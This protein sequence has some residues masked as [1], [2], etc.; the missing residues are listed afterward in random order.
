MNEIENSSAERREENE[1]VFL[2]EGTYFLALLLK[3]KIFIAAFVF[4]ATAGAV[5]ASLMMDNWYKAKVN[6]IPPQQSGSMLE[7]AT[8]NIK[9]TL[10]DFGLTKLTGDADS[11]SLL[12]IFN[13]RSIKD[14]IIAKYN[15]PEVYGIPDTSM[16]EIRAELTENFEAAY[17]EEGNY[18]VSVWDKDPRRASAMANDFIHYFNIISTKIF[19]HESIVNKNYLEKRIA[20]TDSIINLLVDSLS[21]YSK[22]YMIFSPE[23]QASAISDALSDLKAKS[24]EAQTKYNIFRNSYGENDPM[25]ILQKNIASETSRQLSD[26][27][28]RPGFAG[29]FSLNQATEVGIEFI[30]MYTELETYA[31]V[32][33]FLMPSLEKAKLDANS[34]ENNLLYLDKAIP[35]ERK[36]KPKRSLI[37]VGVGAGSFILAILIVIVISVYRRF[38]ERYSLL[39]SDV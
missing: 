8:G 14:S 16:G 37:V 22:K 34:S 24:V 30:K 11:Y 25:T 29:N 6:A 7:A 27:Q 28:R 12:V 13:S 32:K 9:S 36:D 15:L 31:K 18:V 23:D 4:V 2:F 35:P 38:K 17:E 5:V 3:H 19:R 10:K 26:I 39:K 33:A 21:R 1:K 20:V